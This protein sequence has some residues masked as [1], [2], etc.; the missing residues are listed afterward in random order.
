MMR[1]VISTLTI[2]YMIALFSFSGFAMNDR[3][4][5]DKSIEVISPEIGSKDD[6]ILKDGELLINI[7]LNGNVSAYISMYDIGNPLEEE[8]ISLDSDEILSH[9]I[10]DNPKTFELAEDN[11]NIIEEMDE[12]E[13]LDLFNQTE[14]NLE[15]LISEIE[16]MYM[17]IDIILL[18]GDENYSEFDLNTL[19]DFD[20]KINEYYE[21]KLVYEFV[22]DKYNEM[23]KKEIFNKEEMKLE[24]FL[25][26]YQMQ[27]EDLSNGNY[28]LIF[29]DSDD[30]V[31]KTEDF[32]LVSKD[33]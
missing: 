12:D 8:D 23:I 20:S 15:T 16:S 29:T 4:D 22:I 30:N 31:V 5:W 27:V 32:K 13:L 33:K 26:Y 28:Q 18:K 24:G 14:E 11:I 17:S 1:K 9:F 2:I 3:I 21:N 25:P 6:V 10:K 19:R 7:R